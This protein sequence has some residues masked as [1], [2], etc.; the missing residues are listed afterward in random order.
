MSTSKSTI[1]A[2]RPGRPRSE[3]CTRA[4]LDAARQELVDAGYGAMTIDAVAARSGTGKATIYRRWSTKAELVADAIERHTFADIPIDD[5]GDLEVDL[6]RYLEEL[7]R[8]LS[9]IDGELLLALTAER[10][11]N[12]ELAAAFDRRFAT[13]RRGRLRRLLRAAVERGQLPP[14]TDVELLADLGPAL[15]LHALVHGGRARLRGLADRV[16]TQFFASA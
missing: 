11:R 6:R 7:E 9:G 4:I 10:M 2:P 14:S 13:E 3:E 12:P 5:T 1:D 8:A 16:L 15:Y